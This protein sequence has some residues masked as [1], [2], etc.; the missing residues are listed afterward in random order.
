M[1]L[2]IISII[3]FFVSDISDII[4]IFP[5]FLSSGYFVIIDKNFNKS[6]NK[7]LNNKEINNFDF[8]LEYW[9]I[10]KNIFKYNYKFLRKI[11]NQIQNIIQ[12]KLLPNIIQNLKKKSILLFSKFIFFSK[13][14]LSVEKIYFYPKKLDN[15]FYIDWTEII[16]FYFVFLDI[17]HKTI[18]L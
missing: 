12:F 15:I 2:S 16:I 13:K 8:A 9:F 17:F 18:I 10:Y 14:F 3:L 1:F 11:L 6:I 7:I 5:F 4:I